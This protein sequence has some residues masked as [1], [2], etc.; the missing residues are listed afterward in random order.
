MDSGYAVARLNDWPTRLR[1]RLASWLSRLSSAAAPAFTPGVSLPEISGLAMAVAGLALAVWQVLGWLLGT[2]TALLPWIVFGWGAPVVALALILGGPAL[3]LSDRR[4]WQPRWPAVMAGEA[5][6]VAALTL[7]HLSASDPQATALRGEGG[8]LIGWAVSQVLLSLGRLPA[9]ALTA[10]GALAAIW[11]CWRNLPPEWTA[12]LAGTVGQLLHNMG[13]HIEPAEPVIDRSAP[14]VP[15]ARPPRRAA[16]PLPAP[17]ME[18]AQP[19]RPRTRPERAVP[20]PALKAAVAEKPKAAGRAPKRKSR[21]S[22][23]PPLD[24]LEASAGEPRAANSS[25]VRQQA[26]ILK[27]TLDEFGVPVEVVSIKEGPTI[28]Q[29]GLEPGEVVRETSDGEIMRRRVTVNRILRLSNDLALALAAPGPI[30]I[31]APVPGRPYVGIEVPNPHKS[32]VPLRPLLETRDYARLKSPLAIALG[33]DVAGDPVVADLTRMPHLLIAGA[34]G[35][36]KSVCINAIIASLL[37]NNRPEKLRLLMIDP[38]MV[39]LPAYNGIPHLVAPVVTDVSQ[40][41]AALAWLTLQM[42]ERYRAFATA[43][44]RNIEDYN[45]RTGGGKG[46]AADALP[47]LVLIID[48]LA[49]LMMVAPDDVERQICRLAQMARATGIHLVLATQRPSVDVITGLIKANIPSRIAFAVAS[50]VDSRVILDATGAEKLLGRGDMLFMM[51]ESAKIARVQGC[52]VSD[53]E[54]DRVV[55]FWKSNRSEDE[56]AESQSVPWAGLLQQL[57]NRDDLLERALTVLRGKR[58]VST[59]LLQRQLRL[60]YPRAARLMEQLVEMGA[61]GPDEGGGRSREVLLQDE[62]TTAEPE[63]TGDGE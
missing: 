6:L 13:V 43:G 22:A 48:E 29:F 4:G 12:P 19:S 41:T 61:V 24:L 11:L 20:P 50:Q 51:P 28:T 18:P 5:L 63:T 54:I 7:L 42:D 33:R 47:Y 31:E 3:A 36:G 17:E 52:Y 38:K 60:G 16:Q 2:T 59:S 35:S 30:R 23:L 10:L 45:Q 34:T 53:A 44:V 39:E 37:M 14:V 26:L 15:S 1:D 57:E 46:K 62:G 40:T 56:Q 49:D 8:G 25:D 58:Q 55:E 32:M 21:S 9:W 27:Q